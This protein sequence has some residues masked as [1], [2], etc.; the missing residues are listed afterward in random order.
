M[1]KKNLYKKMIAT[2]IAASMLISVAGC[3]T[4]EVKT[5]KA[6]PGALESGAIEAG[7]FE[8]DEQELVN[9]LSESM[10]S[11]DLSSK[12]SKNLVSK[13]PETLKDETVYIF[14]DSEGNVSDVIVN[15]WLKN[16]EGKDVLTD[17]SELKDIE[18]VNGYE[19]CVQNGK[20]LTWEAD[21]SDIVYQGTKRCKA[22][23]RGKSEL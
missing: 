14:E 13:E 8:A 10:E 21:G 20:E 5:E 2:A 1:F 3:G 9:I 6:E 19:T 22:P 15:E 11:D 4:A 7:A 16:P 17:S 12:D 18:N 23:G